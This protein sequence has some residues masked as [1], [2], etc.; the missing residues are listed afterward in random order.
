MFVY[1]QLTVEKL[2]Q[3]TADK[4]AAYKCPPCVNLVGD[5]PRNVMGKVNK[6]VL[7]KQIAQK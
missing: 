1:L 7:Q 6:K 5:L 3:W 2:K 4:L